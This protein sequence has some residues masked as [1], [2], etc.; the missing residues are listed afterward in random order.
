VFS[1]LLQSGAAENPRGGA[2]EDYLFAIAP[3]PHEDAKQG[4]WLSPQYIHLATD[5]GRTK[6]GNLIGK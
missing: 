1:E 3:I 6:S 5:T 4:I 2:F